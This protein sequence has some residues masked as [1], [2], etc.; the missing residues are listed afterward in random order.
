[1][2]ENVLLVTLHTIN[3]TMQMSMQHRDDCVVLAL[4]N[5]VNSFSW[6]L[7]GL[8]LDDHN[9]LTPVGAVGELIIEGPVV[10]VGYL[11]EPEKISQVFI[12]DQRS[13]MPSEFC[14]HPHAAGPI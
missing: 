3:T 2:I 4:Q 10:G 8:I 11:D 6:C 5:K 7:S 14:R 13:R 9:I 1:M 12:E